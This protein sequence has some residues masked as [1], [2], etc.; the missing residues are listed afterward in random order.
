MLLDMESASAKH[1]TV[2]K[3][4]LPLKSRDQAVTLPFSKD[5]TSVSRYDTIASLDETKN[6]VCSQSR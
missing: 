4:Q 3:V 1:G 5:T 2:S 6:N